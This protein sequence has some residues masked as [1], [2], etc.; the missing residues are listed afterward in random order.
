MD[1]RLRVG[2]AAAG[3]FVVAG[4]AAAAPPAHPSDRA[5]LLAWNA[6][7]NR[8][9]RLRLVAARPASGL[10][11]GPGKSFT[12]TWRKGSAPEQTA[13]EACLLMLAKPGRIQVVTG[14][15][16]AGRVEGWSFGHPI[17]TTRPLDANVRLL[18]DGRVTKIY[19][20]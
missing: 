14:I 3:A 2:L 9:N 6:P 16:R 8:P 10:A 19:R 15:W 7:S 4:P 1:P 20:R 5:C 11:L 17:P 13:A 18:P 12:Y